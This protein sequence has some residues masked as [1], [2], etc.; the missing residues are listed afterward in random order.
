MNYQKNFVLKNNNYLVE[1]QKKSIFKNKLKLDKKQMP[2]KL[3]HK[4]NKCS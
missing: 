3:K 4:N 1:R 2:K